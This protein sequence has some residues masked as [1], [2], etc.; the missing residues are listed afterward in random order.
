MIDEQQIKS[1][2]TESNPSQ[3]APIKMEVESIEQ[4]NSDGDMG[5]FALPFVMEH[6]HDL[7]PEDN[8]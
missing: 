5:E 4:L 8:I 3:S 6:L 1:Q 2:P 7:Y